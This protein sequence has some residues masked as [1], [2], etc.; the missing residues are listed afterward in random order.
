[1]KYHGWEGRQEKT[2]RI[3]LDVRSVQQGKGP[4]NVDG[5]GSPQAGAV[6]SEIE[7]TLRMPYGKGLWGESEKK[8][9]K[10]WSRA[11]IRQVPKQ[12]GDKKVS[13]SDF[14]GGHFG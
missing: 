3:E 9:Q 1:M 10:R 12:A 11:D 14:G 5:R 13:F 8:K 7:S 6:L 4:E 2:R